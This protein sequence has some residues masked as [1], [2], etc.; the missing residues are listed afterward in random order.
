[1]DLKL[2]WGE[3]TKLPATPFDCYPEPKDTNE[4]F[5]SDLFFERELLGVLEGS[6][7][8]HAIFY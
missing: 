7:A 2:E 6:T 5:E 8:P 3:E 4:G 1:M